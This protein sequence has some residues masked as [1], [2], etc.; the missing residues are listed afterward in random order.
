MGREQSTNFETA[1]AD[2]LL[3]GLRRQGEAHGDERVRTI[4]RRVLVERGGE[5]VG[6]VASANFSLAGAGLGDKGAIAVAE[7]M[8]KLGSPQT[9]RSHGVCRWTVLLN[10]NGLTDRSSAH[11][12]LLV[13]RCAPPVVLLDARGNAMT[14]AAV[15]RIEEAR[16]LSPPLRSSA[17]P[18][19]GTLGCLPR[20]R[21][22][23][24]PLLPPRRAGGAAVWMRKRCGSVVLR[25]LRP[26]AVRAGLLP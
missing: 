20:R 9:V 17:A 6:A 13:S 19:A 1:F 12:S 21:S 5:G 22:G 2:L 24:A 23:K 18:T 16:E 15:Q 11:L 4:M 26:A 14:P 3:A 7:A 25:C 8:L 10:D